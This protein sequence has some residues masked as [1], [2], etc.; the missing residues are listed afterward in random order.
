V[1]K[2]ADQATVS[3]RA[4]ARG[5]SATDIRISLNTY[6]DAPAGSVTL[7]DDGLHGDGAAGDGIFGGSVLISQ[8]RTG[9]K[10]DAIVTYLNSDV[11]AWDRVLQNIT[12]ANLVLQSYSVASD[13]INNDGTPNPGENVRFVFSMHNATP[14]DLPNL[15]FS[16][17]DPGQKLSLPSL[18]ANSTFAPVYDSYNPSTYLS[19][20]VPPAYRDSEWTEV[21]VTTDLNHN[22]W[23]DTLF[24]PVKPLKY[25]PHNS[26][27][28]HSSGNGTGS[29]SVLIVDST[30][31]KNHIYAI[32]GVD[33]S[34]SIGYTLEDSTTGIVLI[35]NHALPDS[36]GHTSPVVDGFKILRGTIDILPGMKRW[37]VPG[38]TRR[39]SPV[40]GAFFGLE[41]FSTVGDPNA[42]QDRAAGTIGM[43]R[44]LEFGGI[45]T[46]LLNAPDYHD[47]L[48]KWGAVPGDT[49]NP[50]DPNATPTDTNYSLSYRYLGLAT[51]PAAKPSF[52]PWIKDASPGYPYQDYVY[53]VPFS[54][55]DMSYVPPRRLAVG[56]MENNAPGGLVDGRYWPALT[57][58][59][60]GDA[61]GPR[62]MCFIFSSPYTPTPL[63]PF[64]TN[65][66]A[67]ST[68]PIMWVL[69]CARRNDP[70][71]QSGD[72]F[73]IIA[74]HLP[75][76]QD[77]WTFN[78]SVVTS[79]VPPR[80]PGS[81]ALLQNFPNP[82]NPS[83]TIRYQLS[84]AGKVTVKI[85]N[86]LG[87]EVRTLVNEVQ[88]AGPHI[89]IWN[90]QN[91]SGVGVASGVYF[92][93]CE[94]V[95]LNGAGPLSRTMKMLLLK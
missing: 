80:G 77:V 21:L 61:S 60:N 28:V 9:L 91:D 18:L 45:G 51:Q 78:P 62:E 12:T 95:P 11:V 4:D 67:N 1:S 50:W 20:D 48:I 42:P 46:T 6:D 14:M 44:N 43:G 65:I 68:M 81:F 40:G 75:S 64:N 94:V 26:P 36:L 49:T 10:A 31:V 82:F 19:F 7:A 85:Y 53:G 58:V 79:A 90:S 39:F 27:L 41:G 76:P 23:T 13:N 22:Q 73:E 92:Y 69:T 54:A 3:I 83:T 55:W 71:F 5:L 72:Q 84:V 87:Q 57:S 56:N 2:S 15:T 38:G 29:F 25:L 59:D 24:F 86:L 93:R 88:N 63:A 89:S 17:G 8:Y 37:A 70:P 66:S 33:S 74:N 30:Q 32:R 34:G 16:A 35:R 47:V 52:A